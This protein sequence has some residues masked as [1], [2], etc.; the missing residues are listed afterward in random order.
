M[1][2]ITWLPRGI[3]TWSRGGYIPY[4]VILQYH[5]GCHVDCHEGYIHSCFQNSRL[6]L[7]LYWDTHLPS[8]NYLAAA[9]SNYYVTRAFF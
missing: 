2:S 6:D 1:K 7:K 4:M 3:L 5:V 8:G 9:N